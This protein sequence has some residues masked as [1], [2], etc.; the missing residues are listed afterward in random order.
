MTSC[1]QCGE[2]ISDRANF[3][4]NCG[5]PIERPKQIEDQE[6]ESESSGGLSTGVIVLI[7]LL[8]VAF[9]GMGTWWMLSGVNQ[10]ETLTRNRFEEPKEEEAPKP[11][12]KEPVF[13]GSFEDAVEEYQPP[14]ESQPVVVETEPEPEPVV[15][16][17][18]PAQEPTGHWVVVVASLTSRE[19]AQAF[20]DAAPT[21]GLQIAESDGKYRV[22]A[23]EGRTKAEAMA[24]A[25]T[26]RLNTH[27]PDIWAVEL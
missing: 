14:R 27:Y 6:P 17:E 22:Y 16:I 12:A 23:A 2:P 18:E 25:E 13:V 20:I 10:N 26:L 7:A 21:G 15:I 8:A 1:K 24:N 11:V 5:A 9:I 19:A 4:P 3:C